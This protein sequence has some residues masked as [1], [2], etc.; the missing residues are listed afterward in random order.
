MAHRLQHT[1]DFGATENDAGDGSEL[2]WEFD[3]ER[4]RFYVTY[5]DDQ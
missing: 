3:E 4:G 5:P 2:H 1:P